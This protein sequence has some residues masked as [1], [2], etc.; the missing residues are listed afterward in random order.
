MALYSLRLFFL[1]LL[2]SATFPCLIKQVQKARRV[3]HQGW[4]RLG[5]TS[6]IDEEQLSSWPWFIS[7]FASI[8]GTIISQCPLFEYGR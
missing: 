1:F 2:S 6:Q 5:Y 8:N 7:V 3:F 4:E